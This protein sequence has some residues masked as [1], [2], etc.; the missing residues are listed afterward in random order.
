M[1]MLAVAAIEND[2]I[3]KIS[4]L[5]QRHVEINEKDNTEYRARIRDQLSKSDRIDELITKTSKNIG[6]EIKRKILKI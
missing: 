6:T 2:Q 5:L 4:D 3:L 1:E